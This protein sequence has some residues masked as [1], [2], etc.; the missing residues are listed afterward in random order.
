MNTAQFSELQWSPLSPD[1]DLIENL[2]R[3]VE[4]DPSAADKKKK[5]KPEEK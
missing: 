3:L 5:K 2:R 1:L 4:L